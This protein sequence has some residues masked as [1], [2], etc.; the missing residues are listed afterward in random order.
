MITNR[1]FRRLATVLAIFSAVLTT[2]VSAPV[3][4]QAAAG[5]TAPPE[6]VALHD[7]APSILQEIRYNTPH[8]FMGSRI[9]GYEEPLC[10]LTA[11]AAQALAKAERTFLAQGY[12]LKVYDCYRPQRAV[13]TFVTWAEDLDDELMKGEFY[14]RVAKTDL[15]TDGYIAAKSGHSRGSTVD[16]TL[17][18]LP[19]ATTRPYVPGEP[20]APCYAPAK[21]RFPDNSIDMGT[22]YDCFDTLAHTLDPRIVGTQRANRLKLKNALE[23]LGFVNLAEEWWH[24]T[25][26]PETFPSD[27]F[28]FPVSRDSLSD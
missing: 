25:Y 9:N 22:G 16:L 13:D 14:P 2:A 27:Y 8:N 28:D 23:S 3:T 26:S 6:F 1:A 15:F 17:V 18:E 20:L 10:I 21:K 7:V 5:D 12:T 11:P 19:A 4:A 24:F